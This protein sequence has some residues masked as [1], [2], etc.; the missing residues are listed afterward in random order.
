MSIKKFVVYLNSVLFVFFLCIGCTGKKEN[1]TPPVNI[2]P[3]KDIHEV[4]EKV[5]KEREKTA[6]GAGQGL[7]ENEDKR[8]KQ[9]AVAEECLARYNS[10]LEKCNVGSCEDVCFKDLSVCEKD[11]PLHLKTVKEK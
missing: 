9:L 11:L 5:V 1:E 4:Y 2:N 6:A 10:C 7:K 8:K 3:G